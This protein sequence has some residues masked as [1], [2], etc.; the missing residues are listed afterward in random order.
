MFIVVARKPDQR[1]LFARPAGPWLRARKILLHSID[2]SLTCD[3]AVLWWRE[4][5]CWPLTV[6]RSGVMWSALERGGDSGRPPELAN[7]ERGG[8]PCSSARIPRAWT[9]R[10]G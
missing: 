7:P 9:T 4:P 3:V 10:G 5:R 6:E 2:E 1:E 8:A